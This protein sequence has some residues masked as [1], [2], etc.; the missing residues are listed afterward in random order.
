MTVSRCLLAGLSITAAV[1]LSPALAA[2][3]VYFGEDLGAGSPA[4]MTNSFMARDAFMA[5]LSGSGTES[6]ESFADLTDF[7]ANPGLQLNF[8]GTGVTAALSS[9]TARNAPN[10]GR[11]PTAGTTYISA[12][13]NQ[14]ITF[15]TPVAAFGLFVNDA[16]EVDNNPATV[17]VGGLTLTQQQIEARAFDSVDGI[18]RIVTERSPG[19]FEVLFDGGTF[20]ARDSTGMFVGLVDS[21]NPYANIVLINGTSG[22]DSAFQDGFGYDEYTV[23]TVEQLSPIPEPSTWALMLGGLVGVVALARRRAGRPQPA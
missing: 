7:F 17:T 8:G 21:A 15:S 20:P 18:F 9:G 10:A 3:T 6:F 1:G 11:F 19:V 16:G 4:A 22:L 23:G 14:R 5:Q 13:F 2:P 12:S